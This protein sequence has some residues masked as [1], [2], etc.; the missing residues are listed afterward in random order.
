MCSLQSLLFNC[1]YNSSKKMKQSFADKFSVVSF[2]RMQIKL[3]TQQ[4][5]LFFIK[6]ILFNLLL[7]SIFFPPII[8]LLLL[9]FYLLYLNFKSEACHRLQRGSGKKVKKSWCERCK[10]HP[11]THN[12]RKR[13][14]VNVFKIENERNNNEND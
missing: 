2:L 3:T 14:C 1:L 7:S 12:L 13:L 6:S 5:I 11:F 9:S 8:A 4:L 10:K